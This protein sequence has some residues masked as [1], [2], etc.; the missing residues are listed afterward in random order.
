MLHFNRYTIGSPGS[1]RCNPLR[2][3]ALLCMA[4]AL[5]SSP[6]AAQ[7]PQAQDEQVNLESR[8]NSVLTRGTV[9]SVTGSTMIVRTDM[10]E[11]LVFVTDRDTSRPDTVTAGSRV[12][13]VSRRNSEGVHLARSI[14]IDPDGGPSP[15]GPEPIVPSEVRR[16]EG[17]I[18]RQAQRLR[19]GVRAGVGL[20]PEVL[21]VGAHVRVGPFFHRDVWF[22]P[23]IE[24]GF[25]EVTKFGA[26]NLEAIYRL[27]VTERQDRWSVYVGAGPGLN[28]VSRNFEEAEAG[29]R[30]I[31]FDDF[32]FDGSLNF[33]A[34]VESRGGMF[35]E[36]KSTTY[37][38]PQVK[39][40]IGYNF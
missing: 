25:G 18:A 39:I 14:I 35:M 7:Q 10:G 5:C 1:H 27:P 15:T 4:F 21:L 13:I 24:V 30:E 36:F 12:R 40:S 2:L 3:G 32:D 33:L 23:N 20:D 8:D 19:L 38:V 9:V 28:F 26:L 11:H 34:G 6:A 31:D 16:I 29:E 22:R 37:S 17:Q